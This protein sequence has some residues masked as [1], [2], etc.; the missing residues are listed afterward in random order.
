METLHPLAVAL[1]LSALS[2]IRLYLTVFLTGLA[3]HFHWIHLDPQ[4]APLQI[5]AHPA[6]LAVSGTLFLIEFFADKIPWLDSIWD[7]VHTFLRPIGATLL[8]IT[9]LGDAHPVLTIIGALLGGSI[10]LTFHSAKA[11]SRIAINASP[12]PFSNISA[13]LAE[14]SA[15]AGG[16]V[17][18]AFNPL[19]FLILFL[20]IFAILAFLLPRLL[21]LLTSR[22]RFA[23][24]KLTAPP[25]PAETTLPAQLP[26]ELECRLHQLSPGKTTIRWCLPATAARI[27]H[28]PHNS[29]GWLVSILDNH[30]HK[31]LWLPLHPRSAQSIEIPNENLSNASFIR[32]LLYDRLT[33]PSNN[34]KL[35]IEILFDR[36]LQNYTSQ[37]PALLLPQPQSPSSTPEKISA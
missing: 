8:A 7:S 17:L 23:W 25:S 4:F 22:F 3:I 13:S 9:V 31:I 20:A 18:L 34:P 6:V 21:R 30:I 15:T 19:L 28:C 10:A 33:L 1:G 35:S 5:L 11:A 27:P 32:G 37:F 29:Q 36:S 14:D 12:E 16:L 26:I 24:K 2:G